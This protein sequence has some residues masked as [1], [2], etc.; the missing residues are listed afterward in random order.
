M[1]IFFRKNAMTLTELIIASVLMGIMMVGLVSVD[2]AVRNSRAT[3]TAD[4]AV[5]IQTQAA[6]LR[7]TNDAMKAVGNSSNP[8]VSSAA[9]FLCFRHDTDNDPNT[10]SGDT[11]VCYDKDENDIDRCTPSVPEHCTLSSTG[12]ESVLLGKTSDFTYNFFLD[13]TT[14]KLYV[15]ISM[16]NRFDTTVAAHPITN[17]DYTISTHVSPPGHGY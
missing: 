7:I 13:S 9:G 10:F 4:T 12:Y 5:A 16:T 14:K 11:W 2:L 8:G 1:P 6:M 17:P 15:D 3:A